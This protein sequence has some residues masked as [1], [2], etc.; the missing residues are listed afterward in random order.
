MPI[1]CVIHSPVKIYKALVQPCSCPHPLVQNRIPSQDAEA[2][3]RQAEGISTEYARL[4]TQKESL[5]NKLADYEL[6]LGDQVK[7]SK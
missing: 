1:P 7:K 5:E 4:T 6:V 2:L 3:K